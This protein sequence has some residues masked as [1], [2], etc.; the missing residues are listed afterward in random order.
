M[1][2]L[3]WVNSRVKKNTVLANA[4]SALAQ[5]ANIPNGIAFAKQYSV[6]GLQRTL[7]SIFN[8]NCADLSFRVFE[9]TLCRQYVSSF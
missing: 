5:L 8:K 6:K 2:V 1:A 3:N 4:S 7:E 9:R